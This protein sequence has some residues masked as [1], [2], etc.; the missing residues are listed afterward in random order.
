MSSIDNFLS[1]LEK[2]ND[3]ALLRYS[4]GNAYFNEKDFERAVVHF[5]EAVRHDPQYS[6]AWKILGR[7]HHELTQ[8]V[9]AIEAFEQ[10]IAAAQANGDKQAEKEMTVFMRKASKQV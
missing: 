10:G 4:L 6:A 5:K 8:Y 3:N 9:E 2:G 1:M 7:S